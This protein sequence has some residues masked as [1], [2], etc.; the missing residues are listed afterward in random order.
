MRERRGETKE[1]RVKM[2]AR[3]SK[4]KMEEGGRNETEDG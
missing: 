1:I 4:R 2:C 3:G